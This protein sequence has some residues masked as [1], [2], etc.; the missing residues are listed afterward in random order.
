M[1]KNKR[2]YSSYSLSHFLKRMLLMAIPLLMICIIISALSILSIRDQNYRSIQNSV[3]L[4]QETVSSQLNAV[5]H[6]LLWSAVNEPLLEDIEQADSLADRIDALN[7]LRTRVS[8]SQI[9]TGTEYQYFFYLEEV[10]LLFNASVLVMPYQR[11]LQVK[12]AMIDQITSDATL[13][14]NFAWQTA[15]FDGHAYLCCLVTYLNRTL[16]V[17]IDAAD[18]IRPLQNIRP[19]KNG[20]LIVTDL[21]NRTLFSSAEMPQNRMPEDSPFYNR[22]TFAGK[23]ASLPFNI[24]VC[25]DN[26]SNYGGMLFGQMAVCITALCLSLILSGYV[27]YTYFQ[28]IRPI[29]EFS[30]NLAVVNDQREPISLQSSRIRELEQASIQF[31]NLIQEIQKLKI[32][33]YE[34]ELDQKKFQIA[35][36]QKQI[37][38][39]FFLNCLTTISSM[40]QLGKT[41]DIQ[42]M[43][44]VTSRYLHYLFQTDRD[45]VRI[46]YELHHIQA[47]LDIQAMRC[48][49]IFTHECTIRK[50]DEDSLIP[51]LLLITFVENSLKHGETNDGQ[52]KI[53]VHVESE[54][55][56]KE[57]LK[58]DITDSGQGFPAEMLA[59]L[60]SGT[61]LDREHA[62]HVGIANSI[63]RLTLLYGADYDISFFNEKSG[64]AHVRI[65]I[66]RQTREE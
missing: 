16:A 29:R 47:Y 32:H 61:Y 45:T 60:S 51:P 54:R 42:A 41:D 27:L 66:P 33:I 58:I 48:G 63:R 34:Q 26:F 17:Y 22:I 35:F 38:P 19:G 14:H 57:Y 9:T 15:Y 1:K 36:L 37:R 50:E 6:F 44:L 13:E 10:D 11:F 28:V 23:D 8:D 40:A 53:L 64:G 18:L 56:E 55:K 52:L 7:A 25:F 39:H 62:G 4:Y 24:L 46:K 43:V 65:R 30:E 49:P 5:E 31:K 12:R 21:E 3:S 2:P 20:E 59:E